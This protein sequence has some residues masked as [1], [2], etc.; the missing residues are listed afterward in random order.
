MTL[1]CWLKLYH[2][3]IILRENISV[4]YVNNVNYMKSTVY[5]CLNVF[6]FVKETITKTEGVKAYHGQ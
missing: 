1:S 4:N 5:F 3:K 2:F 6:S